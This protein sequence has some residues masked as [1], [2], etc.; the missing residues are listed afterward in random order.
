[1]RKIKCKIYNCCKEQLINDELD[2][3]LQHLDP[4]IHDANTYIAGYV[5]RY[6]CNLCIICLVLSLAASNKENKVG[7]DQIE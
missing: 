7:L 6:V 1:M 2:I 5:E 4:V 3:G